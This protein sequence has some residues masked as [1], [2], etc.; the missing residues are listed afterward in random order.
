MD[1][2]DEPTDTPAAEDEV[3]AVH[4]GPPSGDAASPGP[5]PDE[6][7][8]LEHPHADEALDL[9]ERL[10]WYT[11]PGILLGVP[12]IAWLVTL[13]WSGFYEQV[14]WPYYWGPIKADALGAGNGLCM[15]GSRAFGGCAEGPT[16]FAGYN[17]VNTVSWAVLLG[18]SILG[19]AQMLQ[20][21][22]ITMTNKVILGATAWVIP[23]SIFHV[24]QDTGLFA[25]P[26]EYFFITPPIYLM[27]GAFGV[28]SLLV[29]IYMARVAQEA[30]IH[31]AVQKLW[32]ITAVLVLFYT[33]LWSQ[34]WGQVVA[35]I[36]P[37]VVA[38]AGLAGFL[39]ARWRILGTGRVDPTEMLLILPIGPLLVS[40]AY[41]YQYIRAPWEG[42]AVL[43]LP[44]AVL[45]PL[46]AVAAAAVVYA[47]ARWRHSVTGSDVSRAFMRP[48][49]LVLVGSQTL[50]GVSTG[51]GLDL[52][53]SGYGEK[54]VLSGLIIDNFQLFAERIGW[55][56]AAANPTF[57]AFTPLK[58]LVALAVVYAIDIY[59]KEDLERHPTL[60]GLVKF[61]IIMV[62]IGPGVR[63]F[64][65]MG[66]SV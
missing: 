39:V 9:L 57:V 54:H 63:N 26:L 29:G 52:H 37:L 36:N 30:D 4:D 40:V 61:A 49:N 43:Y 7:D 65:R 64:V 62:G 3:P 20:R 51:I 2:A 55:A 6:G 46:I 8:A 60:I 38:L 56:F 66:L 44:A 59:S 13:V 47:I 35:Y 24:L 42:V 22:R 14:I 10:P 15:D 16:A 18:V 50:D 45:A 48:I 33:L 58:V 17:P 21:L 34:A 28:L 25:R 23:G 53:P 31:A 32:F 5:A 11:V 12:L 19:L 1:P 41:V 27:F